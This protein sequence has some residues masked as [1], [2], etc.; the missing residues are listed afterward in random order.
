MASTFLLS[1]ST[2]V[3]RNPLAA[4]HAASGAPSFP[5]PT[6]EIEFS[7]ILPSELCLQSRI[8]S[9]HQLPVLRKAITADHRRPVRARNLVQPAKQVFLARVPKI[10]HLRRLLHRRTHPQKLVHQPSAPAG[11]QFRARYRTAPRVEPF[12]LLQAVGIPMLAEPADQRVHRIQLRMTEKAYPQFEIARVPPSRVHSRAVLLPKT[13][14]P[15]CRL[16]LNVPVRAAEQKA[17]ARPAHQRID[18]RHRA[19]FVEY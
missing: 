2:A 12:R 1:T 15:K 14:P 13:P 16:L 3:M 19:L 8:P 6:T 9:L 7:M 18:S 10:P 4:K 17:K 11:F 5:S